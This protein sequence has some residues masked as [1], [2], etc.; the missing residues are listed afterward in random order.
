MILAGNTNIVALH[1]TKELKRSPETL[2]YIMFLAEHGNEVYER[3]KVHKIGCIRGNKSVSSE[4]FASAND[5]YEELKVPRR[6]FS[7]QGMSMV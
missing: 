7:R 6:Q 4:V 1:K 5:V 3:L 2:H